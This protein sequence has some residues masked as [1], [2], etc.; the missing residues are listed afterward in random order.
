MVKAW[1]LRVYSLTPKVSDLFAINSYGIKLLF[2]QILWLIWNLNGNGQ[3]SSKSVWHALRPCSP[4][5]PWAKIVWF[6]RHVARWSFIECLIFS[7]RLSTKDRLGRVGGSIQVDV[8]CCLCNGPMESHELLFFAC[9]FS[10]QLSLGAFLGYMRIMLTGVCWASQRRE[11]GIVLI[12]LVSLSSMLFIGCPWL[13]PVIG[14]GA[15]K[16]R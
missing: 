11:L 4:T 8:S 10:C 3:F 14:F 6:P 16:L 12:R 2:V 13:L 15:S 1:D 7:G 9:P 5:S